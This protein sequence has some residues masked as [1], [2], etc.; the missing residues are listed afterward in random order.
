MELLKIAYN[1]NLYFI[2]IIIIFGIIGNILNIFIFTRPALH[3]SCSIYFLAGSFN[4]LII[5][6]FGTL[7]DWFSQIFPVLNPIGTSL[8]YCR[9]LNYFIYVIYN[10]APYFTAC[11]TIDRFLSSCPDANLR[12]LS[13]RPQTAYIVIPIVILM[14]SIAYIHIPIR[15]TIIRSICQPVPGFY[16][17]F[18]P[19]FT[20]GYY[21]FAIILIIIFGLGTSYNIRSR[22]RRIQ[23]LVNTNRVVERR[24]ARGDAQLLIILFVHVICYAALALPFHIT[25]MIAAIKPTLAVNIIF[26]FAQQIT[27]VTLNLSQSISFYVFTLTAKMYRKELI[28]LI[29]RVKDHY[30]H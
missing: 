15:Y 6:I 16:A 26:L 13:S 2:P 5:L 9:F 8:S 21:F 1:I 11:I 23:P 22:R 12:R 3:R 19:F 30:W 18:F 7:N 24:R 4:G 28:N 29:R 10:L 14:T 20:T 17:N 27:F 25:L